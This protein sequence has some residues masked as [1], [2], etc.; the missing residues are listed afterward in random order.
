M[1]ILLAFLIKTNLTRPFSLFQLLE[2]TF[3]KIYL[4]INS[5]EKNNTI[6]RKEETATMYQCMVF[7][8]CEFSDVV[9]F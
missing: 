2:Q 9:F 4:T 8:L 5:C 7:H 6:Q 3:K 1:H